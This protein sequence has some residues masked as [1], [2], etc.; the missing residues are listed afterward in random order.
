MCL[1]GLL[2]AGGIFLFP[3]C[4]EKP[5]ADG[6]LGASSLRSQGGLLEI[7]VVMDTL[8]W[9]GP[10]GE[11]LRSVFM[12]AVP[13]LP[14]DEPRFK[15]LSVEPRSFN[16]F[17]KQ[18]NNVMFIT[19]FDDNS[20][21]SKRMKSY[22]TRESLA[23]IRQDTSRFVLGK[24]DEFARG[25]KLLYLFSNNARE[26][27]QRI[28]SQRNR[29]L[30]YFYQAERARLT[31]RLLGEGRF[32]N[33]RL[34][35]LIQKKTG[36]QLQIPEGFAKAKTDSNFLWIREKGNPYDRSITITYGQYSSQEMFDTAQII[37][38]REHFGY[39][40]MNDNPERRAYMSTQN[41]MVPLEA[42][43]VRLNGKFAM[44]Y[45]GLW[46]LKNMSQGG[47]FLGY[48]FVDEKKRRF[49]YVE[50]FL[51]A[52]T[53]KHRRVMFELESVL[54]TLKY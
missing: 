14:R 27:I 47:P 10:I 28:R 3:G 36:L 19:V 17:L 37:R 48:A 16:R 9:E 8:Q 1:L 51:Y 42:R 52:P 35:E 38:W 32:E 34:G 21:G 45:R 25:Q 24:R 30:D 23:N 39:K 49:Y 31:A 53:E 22:F 50:A 40:F 43:P 13:G 44:E 41:A 18:H 2:L 11:A 54:H 26:M 29:L 5:A 20:P 12:E 15:L 4:I 7:V 33:A 46:M 6:K